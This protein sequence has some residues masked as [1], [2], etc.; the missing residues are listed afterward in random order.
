MKRRDGVRET[1]G[2]SAEEE[3]KNRRGEEEDEKTESGGRQ[4]TT[5]LNAAASEISCEL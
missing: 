2:E 3:D 5:Q 4:L 1:R